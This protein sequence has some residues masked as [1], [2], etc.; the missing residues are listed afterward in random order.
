MNKISFEAITVIK[1]L[2]RN[3]YLAKHITK[4]DTEKNS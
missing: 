1:L 3:V 4:L 2:L